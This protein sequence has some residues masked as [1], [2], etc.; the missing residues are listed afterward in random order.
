MIWQLDNA[1][2]NYTVGV[3]THSSGSTVSNADELLTADGA[4]YIERDDKFGS[5]RTCQGFDTG[6]ER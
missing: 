5:P 1:R 4:R 6:H 2:A 3:T